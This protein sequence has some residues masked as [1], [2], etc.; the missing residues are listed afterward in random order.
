MNNYN[1]MGNILGSGV[2]ILFKL[3]LYEY[4]WVV[5]GVEFLY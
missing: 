4:G 3:L 1:L 5:M 2:L